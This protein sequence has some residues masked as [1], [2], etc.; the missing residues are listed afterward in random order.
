M[1]DYGQVLAER[2]APSYHDT[3]TRAKDC[4]DPAVLAQTAFIVKELQ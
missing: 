4:S 1:A 2:T 3:V